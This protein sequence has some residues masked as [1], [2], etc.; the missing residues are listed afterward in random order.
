MV[1]TNYINKLRIKDPVK[2]KPWKDI[3]DATIE[4]EGCIQFSLLTYEFIGTED[5][6]FNNIHTTK[7]PRINVAL[8]PV[9]VNIHPGAYSF[10]SPHTEF[11]GS[12]EFVMHNDIVYVCISYRLHILGFLNLKLKECAGNQGIKD[13]VLSLRWIKAN[14][15]AFG[16]DPDNVTLLGSSSGSALVHILMLSPSAKG[17]FHKAVLMSGHLTHSVSPY[18]KTNENYA[19][20][21]AT[22]IGYDGNLQ[23]GKKILMFL[24]KQEPV[25][26]IEGFRRCQNVLHQTIAPIVPMCVFNPT[27]DQGGILS[28]L[29]ENLIESMTRI[30]IIIGFSQIESV[31]GFIRSL[32]PLTEKN[33]K[34]SLRQNCFGWGY[35]CSDDYIQSIYKEAEAF[36]LNGEPVEQAPLPIKMNI[37]TDIS[38]SDIYNTIINPISKDLPSS[39]FV[40]KFE[41][42]GNIHSMNTTLK[43]MIDEPIKGTCHGSDFCY[44]NRMGDPR[45]KETRK[46]V[47]TFTKLITTFAEKGDPNYE[48][49]LVKW[50]P[51]TLEEPCH[52]SINQPMV[53]VDG[54]LNNDRLEFWERIQEKY[55]AKE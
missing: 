54:K 11:Y 32:R 42:E 51:C 9:I 34:N 1:Y 28:D 3:K 33:F 36:Y 4:K 31:M 23:D 13:I 22:N 19:R 16:G 52:L 44:W 48:N 29:P 40:Y 8:R 10:G 39:V 41:F 2:A 24:K 25:I 45:D 15:R 5:C 47:E 49:C 17:L 7:L 27:L 43:N 30:P 18:R 53:M 50:K 20:E 38:I 37:Q 6:L 21:M 26:L 14:I 35:H 46:M 55:K 12:P